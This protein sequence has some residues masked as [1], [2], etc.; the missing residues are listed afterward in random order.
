MGAPSKLTAEQALAI[1]ATY[2]QRT[3]GAGVASLAARYG[4]SVMLIHRVLRG[5]HP[6]ARGLADIAGTRGSSFADQGRTNTG[7][8]PSGGA[9]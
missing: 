1:R 7:S 6:A 3:G 9:S 4:V 8:Y 5:T 2:T